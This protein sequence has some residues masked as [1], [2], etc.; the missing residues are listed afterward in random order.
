[1]A[2][3]QFT[4][5]AHMRTFLANA[6][7][8]LEEFDRCSTK[9]TALLFKE[10]KKEVRINVESVVGKNTPQ[11]IRVAQSVKVIIRNPF[12]RMQLF[13]V[14]RIVN[15]KTIV[16]YD[17]F[18]PGWTIRETRERGELGRITAQ[19]GCRQEGRFHTTPDE[20]KLIEGN[21]LRKPEVKPSTVYH[22]TISKTTSEWYSL[23]TTRE[24]FSCTE[25]RILKDT[26]GTL[27]ELEPF[28]YS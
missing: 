4:S 17:P 27:I 10:T 6:G 24:R 9:S 1:M 16:T 23:E 5:E 8:D 18:E 13:E 14:R 2:N 25:S 20:F 7:F 21:L 22:N 3:A 28:E 11:I 26:S 19:K 15:G 12:E